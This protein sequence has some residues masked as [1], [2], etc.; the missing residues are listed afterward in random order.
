MHMDL[1]ANKKGGSG[2]L[3]PKLCKGVQWCPK[4]GYLDNKTYQNRKPVIKD[5]HKD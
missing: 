1:V 4:S 3:N 2:T 5:T